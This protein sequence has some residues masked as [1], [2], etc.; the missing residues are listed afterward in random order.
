MIYKVWFVKLWVI[1]KVQSFFGNNDLILKLD[2]EELR[3]YQI[4]GRYQMYRCHVKAKAHP[5]K[6]TKF[7]KKWEWAH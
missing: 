5:S 2:L 7:K 1:S 3:R 4:L 6:T